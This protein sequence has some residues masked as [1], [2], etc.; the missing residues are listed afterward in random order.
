MAII[1]QQLLLFE[2]TP[3]E[4]LRQEFNA[5]KESSER[6]RKGQF[7]KIGSAQKQINDMKE[8]LDI[9]ERGICQS[10]IEERFR[11]VLS[12]NIN[13]KKQMD[14]LQHD[15]H[16]LKGAFLPLASIFE[17]KYDSI[18]PGVKAL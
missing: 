5:L 18:E 10:D 11:V 9:L 3:E 1:T 4:K 6:V 16:Q 13:M 8:R 2:L 17:R 15:F 7:A 14:D 12:E